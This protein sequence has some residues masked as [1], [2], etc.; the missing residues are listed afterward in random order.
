MKTML[1]GLMSF[2]SLTCNSQNYYANVI[3]YFTYQSRIEIYDTTQQKPRITIPSS[4]NN[5]ADDGR[6]TKDGYFAYRR[7]EDGVSDEYCFLDGSFNIASTFSHPKSVTGYENIDGHCIYKDDSLIIYILERIIE[8]PEPIFLTDMGNSS[9]VIDNVI[10]VEKNGITILEFSNWN[11]FTPKYILGEPKDNLL[12]W[13]AAHV[14]SVDWDGTGILVSNLCYGIYKIDIEGNIMWQQDS[15]VFKGPKPVRQHDLQH[16]GNGVYSLFSNGDENNNLF[17][18]TF[19]I[20]NDTVIYDYIHAP[21]IGFSY[22]M[23][24]FQHKGITNYGAHENKFIFTDTTKH[25]NLKPYEYAYRAGLHNYTIVANIAQ[26]GDSLVYTPQNEYSTYT[27]SNGAIGNTIP[28]SPTLISVTEITPLGFIVYTER[29]YGGPVGINE[30][31]KPMPNNNHQAYNL[32]GQPVEPK[33]LY[34][35]QGKVYCSPN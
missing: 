13:D 27:W 17:A 23:G 24:N 21:K 3:D 8:L 14:N 32:N 9:H 2:V 31:N 35:K 11:H 30:V 22:S 4:H 25:H 6:I 1:F 19:S 7:G 28:Y 26:I 18:A 34:I 15:L 10:M 5:A 29:N 16:I 12:Y 33:G 20:Q